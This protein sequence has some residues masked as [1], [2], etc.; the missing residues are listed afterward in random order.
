MSKACFDQSPT[1][2]PPVSSCL[3]RS[4]TFWKFPFLTL[5]KPRSQARTRMSML[6]QY[7]SCSGRWPPH[8]CPCHRPPPHPTLLRINRC[9]VSAL[10]EGIEPTAAELMIPSIGISWWK[11]MGAI[12]DIN[13][14]IDCQHWN[15]SYIRLSTNSYRIKHIIFCKWWLLKDAY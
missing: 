7:C 14:V 15:I 2:S 4:K 9:V 6:H 10:F 1:T 12:S 8:S 3:N 11:S 13:Q 5:S